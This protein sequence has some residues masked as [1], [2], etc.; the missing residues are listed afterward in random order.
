M[1]TAKVW[2]IPPAAI[3]ALV[4]HNATPAEARAVG[5]VAFAVR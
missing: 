4:L 3:R 2:G 1:A 5:Q